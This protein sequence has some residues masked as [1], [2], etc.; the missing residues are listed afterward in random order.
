MHIL[1]TN[2]DGIES[3]GLLALATSLRALAHV[4][5]IA[6]DRER[7][8]VGHAVTLHKPLRARE[9]SVGLEGVRAF[10][11]NGTPS[12]CVV[13]G[14][15]D[16]MDPRPTLVASGI[17]GGPNLG[18]DVLYSGT[19]AAAMEGAI[20]GVPS[21]AISLV[22]RAPEHEQDATDDGRRTTDD[23]TDYGYA[24][25]FARE[26]AQTL[27]ATGMTLPDG[28]FLN[29]NVPAVATDEIRGVRITS[30]GRRRWGERL[31][32]RQDPRGE[33]YYWQA[34]D[35]FQDGNPAGTDIAA[36]MDGYVS[37]TPAQLDLTSHEGIRQLESLAESLSEGRT[38]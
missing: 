14:A 38:D 25:W 35:P 29:V 13:L 22:R 4:T 24:A 23:G 1:V 7:S 28:V 3:P 37:I 17:N 6:P 31:V 36:I 8:A 32:K 19:V 33:T 16:L 18:D 27:V 30:L 26:L 2:D 10:V 34:G 9:V 21:F 15:L 20:M 5:I 11:S 12:D